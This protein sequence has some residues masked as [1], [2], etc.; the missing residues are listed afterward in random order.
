MTASR[1]FA[2]VGAVILAL[3]FAAPANAVIVLAENFNDDIDNDATDA[4]FTKSDSDAG[5]DPDD[6]FNLSAMSE[7]IYWGIWDDTGITDDFGG[8]PVPTGGGV[9]GG[10]VP[11][12]VGSFVGNYLVAEQT[13]GTSTIPVVDPLILDWDDLDI[14]GLSS[15]EFSGLFA[16]AVDEF[17]PGDYILVQYRIDN[18]GSLV[19]LLQF[20]GD[21]GGE[22]ALDPDFDETGTGTKLSLT[23]AP[24][25]AAITG[26]GTTLDLRIL[27]ESTGVGEA[28]AFDSIM[29]VGVPE[30]TAFLFG[31][32][33]CGVMGM[34]YAFRSICSSKSEK[35]ESIADHT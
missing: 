5:N 35:A 12:Y 7:D 27:M 14:D 21:A 32:L 30:P 20:S 31:G 4:P 26:T 29:I 1:C 3:S 13:D 17:N 16:A 18:I 8:D 28:F 10:Q 22:L 11:D 34:G 33:V 2:F 23:A 19:D 15:L 25:T 24:F 9:A 6:F